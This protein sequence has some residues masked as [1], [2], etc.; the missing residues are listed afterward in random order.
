MLENYWFSFSYDG[1]NNGVCVVQAEDAESAQDKIIN[2]GLMPKYD[3]IYCCI[4]GDMANEKIGYN[5]L[6]SSEEMT[7]LG[8]T[9]TE[10]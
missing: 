4:I 9:I 2:L 6:Y 10:E 7:A 1:A 8:Y 5:R 3:D